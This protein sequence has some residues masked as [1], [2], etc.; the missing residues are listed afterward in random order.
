[1]TYLRDIGKQVPSLAVLVVVV[2]IFLHFGAKIATQFSDTVVRNQEANALIATECHTVQKAA[3]A[4][5]SA[6][7]RSRDDMRLA[8]DNNTK[9]TDALSKQTEELTRQI[10]DLR[11]AVNSK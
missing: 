4:A 7:T 1:M 8:V 11:D 10:H 3:V 2:S 5:I 6:D 9:A